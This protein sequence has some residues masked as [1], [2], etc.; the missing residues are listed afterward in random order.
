MLIL[1]NEEPG[2]VVG[3][4]LF[5]TIAAV[6]AAVAAVL[7]AV[8]TASTFAVTARTSLTARVTAAIGTQALIAAFIAL[9][10]FTA[11]AAC[12]FINALR[13]A[14][15]GL[16]AGT[17][18]RAIAILHV[19]RTARVRIVCTLRE[20]RCNHKAGNRQWDKYSENAHFHTGSFLDW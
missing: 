5:T 17:G 1:L 13:R 3:A 12:A 10:G 11:C 2:H 20:C 6:I 16:I 18:H 7:D 19:A 15:L 9:T 14:V 4:C 8:G